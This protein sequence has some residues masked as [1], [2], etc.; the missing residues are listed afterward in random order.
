ML[1][2]TDEPPDP[3]QISDSHRVNKSFNQNQGETRH[4]NIR[5]RSSILIAIVYA[6]HTNQARDAPIEPTGSKRVS[7][8]RRAHTSTRVAPTSLYV[9]SVL[10]LVSSIRDRGKDRSLKKFF[11]IAPDG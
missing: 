9:M 6:K 11:V 7:E 1:H 2:A 8:H 4:L 3:K 10:E 5:V